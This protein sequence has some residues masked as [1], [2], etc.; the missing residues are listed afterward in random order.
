MFRDHI[1]AVIAAARPSTLDQIFKDISGRLAKQQLSDDDAS[2]AFSLI[3]ARRDAFR[4][5]Q[6]VMPGFSPSTPITLPPLPRHLFPAPKYQP[7]KRHPERIKRRRRIAQS[8]PLPPQ[9][10]AHFTTSQ[11]SVLAIIA[12]EAG[13]DGQC[14]LYMGAIAAR[15]GVCVTTARNAIKLAT[16]LGLLS[17]AERRRPGQRS[18]STVLRV[19]SKEWRVWIQRGG[20][21]ATGPRR[22]LFRD[23]RHEW[24]TEPKTRSSCSGVKNTSRTDRFHQGAC[25]QPPLSPPT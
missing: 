23:L 5:P 24:A 10:G 1:A 13:A 19:I 8:G 22:T 18:L 9:L 14:A 11:I 3:Q 25:G 20:K 17:R 15:A 16:E 2:L 21:R 4:D 6:L 12:D 7:A